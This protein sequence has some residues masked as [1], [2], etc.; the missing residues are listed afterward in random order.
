MLRQLSVVIIEFYRGIHPLEKY[1]CYR[2]ERKGCQNDSGTRFSNTR[3]IHLRPTSAKQF[4][5]LQSDPTLARSLNGMLE[6]LALKKRIV[7]RT[8]Y[9]DGFG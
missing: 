6:Q 5:K 4:Y 3:T 1:L 8:L 9:F 2:R 7:K